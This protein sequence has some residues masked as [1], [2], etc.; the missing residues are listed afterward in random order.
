[1][2][3]SKV[4]LVRT[5]VKTATYGR[6][7]EQRFESP[8]TVAF[9]SRQP[10]ACI[11]LSKFH[12]CVEALRAWEKTGATERTTLIAIQKQVVNGQTRVTSTTT[13][14]PTSQ[15]DKCP[16]Q[17]VFSEEHCSSHLSTSSRPTDTLGASR[18]CRGVELRRRTIALLSLQHR[19]TSTGGAIEA[20][21]AAMN[22]EIVTRTRETI[23]REALD[24]RQLPSSNNSCLQDSDRRARPRD[25][26]AVTCEV[27]ASSSAAATAT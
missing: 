26:T 21:E 16:P 14:T 24:S 22:R 3:R 7:T 23:S 2:T 4:K 25:V 15:T 10:G 5:E 17:C 1:M 20:R 13:S 11:S 19:S 8:Q 9:T 18:C 6:I 12:V 27:S